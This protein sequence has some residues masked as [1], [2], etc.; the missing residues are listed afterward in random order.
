MMGS[1]TG[2]HPY[3]ARWL[4]RKKCQQPA[5]R[6]SELDD[7]PP[8]G[9]NAMYLKNRLPKVQSDGHRRLHGSSPFCQPLQAGGVL[10]SRPQH[11]KQTFSST[12]TVAPKNSILLAVS[13]RRSE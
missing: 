8:T 9:I 4:F 3:K 2:F 7:D 12:P 13:P 1:S 11:Q 6:Q 5:S 10:K